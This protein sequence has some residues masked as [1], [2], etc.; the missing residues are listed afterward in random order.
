MNDSE[1]VKCACCLI[2]TM[3][4]DHKN[5]YKN[6]IDVICGYCKKHDYSFVQSKELIKDYI[7]K[8]GKNHCSN[9]RNIGCT[10]TCTTCELYSYFPVNSR[11]LAI[12]Y[13]PTGNL[14][15]EFI[16]H[17]YLMCLSFRTVKL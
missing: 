5:I 13:D 12:N 1:K 17:Q 9:C 3:P 8:V 15:L 7:V 2:S 4:I 11:K 14:C 6:D 10:I 16:H